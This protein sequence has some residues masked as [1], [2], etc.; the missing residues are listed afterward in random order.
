MI[1]S[2]REQAAFEAFVV[3]ASGRLMRT[4]YLLCQDRG[5]AE[6]LVQA[7]LMRTA[8][9]WHR[10]QQQPEAYARRTLVNLAKN[11]WRTL[12]R[13]VTEIPAEAEAS[14]L[15]RHFDDTVLERQHLLTAVRELSPGQRAVLVLRFFDD[16][17]VA[18]TAAA[19]NCTQGTVKSQTARALNQMRRVLNQQRTNADVDG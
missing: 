19:L 6:D 14:A 9:R 10:A 8:R 12:Q 3:D 5:H 15:E 7:T 1:G 13:R 17:S 4:A 18:E 16:L 2:R 11:R